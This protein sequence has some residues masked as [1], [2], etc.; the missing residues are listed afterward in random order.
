MFQAYCGS[1]LNLYDQEVT[2]RE[3]DWIYR[4]LIFAI[5]LA[6]PAFAMAAEGGYAGT[7]ACL[8]C[9]EEI[10]AAFTS[11]FHAKAWAGGDQGCEACHGPGAQHADNPSRESIGTFGPKA[12]RAAATQS[13]ACL[14][15]HAAATEIALWSQGIHGRRDVTCANCHSIHKGFS[16]VAA[17][18]TVC[19]GCHRNVKMDV[20]KQ[21]HH[22]IQEG[23]V[24][25]ESCHNPHGTLSK[26]LVRNDTVN[27]LCYDCHADKRGP[28]LWEH[29][30]VEEDC[31]TCHTPHGSR[32]KNLLVQKVPNLCQSCHDWSRHPGTPYDKAASFAGRAPSN[33][34]LGR[35]CNNCHVNIH[36][37][38]APNDPTGTGH[39]N[40]Q[41]YLR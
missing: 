1:E 21:S 25:C 32:H 19:Y 2:V 23:K 39:N 14:R 6:A 3:T 40:G 26:H 10:G 5:L 41:A 15:C 4:S 7:K 12:T 18:P 27:Q 20:N 30:P 34:F 31:T 28:Y 11:S 33:R 37:S 38:M 13:E 36:G 29:P 17:T 9:H 24:A 16:P 22:P 8:E 35:S